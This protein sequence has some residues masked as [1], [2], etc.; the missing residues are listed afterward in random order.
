M[1][2]EKGVARVAG[3]GYRS[4]GTS[5]CIR[6]PEDFGHRRAPSGARAV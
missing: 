4:A 2:L 6:A 5:V 1:R 3:G